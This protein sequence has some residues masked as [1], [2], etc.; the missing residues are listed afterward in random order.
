MFWGISEAR[1]F[2][3]EYITAIKQRPKK[4]DILFFG[5]GDPGH[6]LKTIS[7]F[8]FHNVF[9]IEFNFYILEGCAELIARDMMLLSI[10]FEPEE[11]FSIDGKTQLYMDIFG[12][13]ML[14]S[15]SSM[16]L[17]AK[18]EIFIKMITDKSF[19]QQM[20]PMF[21]FE[22]LKYKE[23]DQMEMAFTFWKNKK[24]HIYDIKKYWEDQNRVQLKERFD[25]RNGAF[26][27]DLQMRLKHNGAKQICPQEYKHWRECGVAFT[28]PEFEYTLPNKTFAMDL[29]KNGKEWFHRGYVGDMSVGPF[30][31]FG[32]TCS[33]EKMNN[34][35]FG[36]N[37]CRSTDITERN[38]YEILWEILH[39][40]KFDATNDKKNFRK[41]GAVT[42]QVGN[43]PCASSRSFEDID[44]K[45]VKYDKPLKS[46]DN[47]KIH[48]LSI[49]DIL[50]I[51]K[52]SQYTQKFDIV[53]VANN[54]FSFL[55]EDFIEILNNSSFVM[56]E[57]K[58]YSTLKSDEI[59]KQID[60][61]KHFSKNIGLHAVTNFSMNVVNS[62][63]KY[64]R[65]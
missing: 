50:N 43:S 35:K 65:I 60:D 15:T 45:L 62:V 17:N 39:Q 54:Y 20:M 18:S 1:D 36:T 4:L 31:T 5:L 6:I 23:R 25:H 16:Y 22:Q 63:L 42:L 61:I 47:I 11:N 14:S 57:T 33:E 37:E 53:F 27:W 9:D 7:K 21:N 59:N 8:F 32:M 38:L 58:K 19:A 41:F 52:K 24:E 26:D 46:I 2:Y 3:D 48:F 44:I 55:K 49:D 51:T 13:S 64:K 10:P 28:F 56:F 34:S 40:Q 29:R 12:N 30:I